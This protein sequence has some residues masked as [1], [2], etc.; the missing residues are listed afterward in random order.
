MATAKV[1]VSLPQDDVDWLKDQAEKS[2]RSLSAVLA[3]SIQQA[4]REQAL[5]DVLRWLEAPKL[6]IEQ[7]EEL[8]ALWH[9]D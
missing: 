9:V 6:T 8:R 2:G 4:R 5:D 3:E 7:L 1:S